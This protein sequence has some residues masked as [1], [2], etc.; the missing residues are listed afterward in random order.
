M[1]SRS[2]DCLLVVPTGDQG[3][4]LGV[5]VDVARRSYSTQIV[6]REEDQKIKTDESGG[7]LKPQ[8]FFVTIPQVD[9]GCEI[10]LKVSWSQKLLYKD[11]LFAVTVPF[12]FPD[13][14]N[15]SAKIFSKREKV[16][17]Y[18]NTSTGKEVVIQRTSHALKE[19]RR[20]LGKMSFL[21]E[22]N[23]EYWSTQDFHFSY[24]IYSNDLFG[25]V[26]LQ[27]PSVHDYD[28]REMFYL[29]L[30]PG[31]N[32]SRKVFRKEVVFLVDISGSMQGKPLENVKNALSAAL[33][34]LSSRD[35]FN[36]IA[37]NEEMHFFSSSLEP[38]TE[39]SIENATQWISKTFVASGGT[40]ILQPLNEA[41][42]QLSKTSEALPHIF[43]VT[44]GSVEGERDICC[45]MRTH[46]SD[47]GSINPRISTFG[48]G[49]Y[50]NH[51]FLRMLSS[52]GRG[53]YEAACDPDSI[54]VQMRRW[55]RRA[56][57]PILVNITI[58]ILDHLEAF[59][60][61]P[62]NI[63]DLSLGCPLVVSGRYEGRFPDSAKAKGSLA[64]M[65]DSFVDLKVQIAKDTP[66]DKVLAKQQ[67][68][69]L[70]SQAWFS[71]SKQLEEKVIKRSID[72]GI[73][74]EY[75]DMILLRHEEEK[76]DGVKQAKKQD[77]H[78]QGKTKD[79]PINLVHGMKLGF[80]N[81]AATTENLPTGFGELK[82]PE[83]SHVL[84]KAAGCCSKL[85]DCC[86]CMCFIKACSKMNDQC[87][88]ALTQLCTALSFL[89][90]FECCS[91]CCGGGSD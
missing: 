86:C 1:G 12:R 85:C 2:C 11:G 20:G 78:K 32:L 57:S 80:G 64:D 69:L 39:D 15:P 41:M 13:F 67:I 9:G 79:Q 61:Y 16:H 44:D 81:V 34:E 75:T 55:F 87:V 51:Y 91:L 17:L 77:K 66:L 71:E 8:L 76:Q 90:C 14:V 24:S 68:D 30:F 83:T 49:T 47:K 5:E 23:V 88:I 26:L 72:S 56:L 63:P 31:S 38:T 65:S 42:R 89:A 36:I 6:Q 3:S 53:Q 29:Y 10:S 45:A 28:Q 22:A 33:L 40:N 58:D 73:P 74:A 37:F 70:T 21:Y 43:L 50:C 48:I 27:S 19:E 25:G 62:F 52:I 35:Y 54:E 82:P 84:V 7:L 60:V 59:E 46:M 18:V 4:I